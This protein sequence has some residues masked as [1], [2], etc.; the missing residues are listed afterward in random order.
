MARA[1]IATSQAPVNIAV[2][3]YWGKR[4]EELILPLNDSLSL[5]IN[6]DDLCATT[7][8]AALPA[9]V[10]DKLVL[11]G[12]ALYKLK[13]NFSFIARKGSGSACR[14]M[15]G[16]FVRWRAGVK[17]DGSDSEAIQIAPASHWP[18][19]RIIICVVSDSKKDTGSTNGM[20]R[21]VATSDLLK[22]RVK[23]IV[24]QRIEAMQ[25]AI[26]AKD[27]DT[28]AR[29]TM[30]DSNQMH[31]VCQDTY[32]P[33]RYMNQIS[34]DIIT[35]VHRYNEAVGATKLAYTFDAGPNAFL[36]CLEEDVAEVLFVLTKLF[37]STELDYVRGMYRIPTTKSTPISEEMIKQIDP[38]PV[39]SLKYIITTKVGDG[40]RIIEKH[41]IN[42]QGETVF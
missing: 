22:H 30:I 28:F 31:A 1:G 21:S 6:T 15:F 24:P 35:L 40:P 7:S 11:N 36:F 20:Q 38:Y 4:D 18:E 5:T 23:N 42:D 12:K 13:G 37:P 34:W 2:V 39:G 8:V 14:S 25:K 10:E 33:V 19:I 9:N 32:P 29:L 16:G 26:L 27:F 17:A 41:L 3:K